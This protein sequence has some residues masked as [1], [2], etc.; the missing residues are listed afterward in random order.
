M[1]QLRAVKTHWLTFAA[2]VVLSGLV[3]AFVD[4]TP[5]VDEHFFFSSG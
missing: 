3:Y 5:H 4:L 1:Q 2:T